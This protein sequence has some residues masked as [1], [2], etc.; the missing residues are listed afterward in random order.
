M[1]AN[2]A[3]AAGLKPGQAGNASSA[4]SNSNS[5][6]ILSKLEGPEK[7]STISKTSTDWDVLVEAK[8]MKDELKMNTEDGYLVKKDFLSRVDGRLFERELGRR[9]G[10]RVARIGSNF[11]FVVNELREIYLP[12][13]H[14]PSFICSQFFKTRRKDR[15][16]GSSWLGVEALRGGRGKGTVA[17]FFT[18]EKQ[19]VRA[20]LT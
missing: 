9:R 4:S 5:D 16:E 3:A 18:C 20:L 14:T 6:D 11:V 8:G 7:I 17:W 15:V 13:L 2:E 19:T 12:L 10:R 1:T